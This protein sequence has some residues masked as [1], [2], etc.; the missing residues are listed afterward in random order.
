[1]LDKES[2]REIAFQYAAEVRRVLNPDAV[3]LFGSYANG[4]PHAMSDIDIAVIMNLFQG[5]WLE[6]SALLSSLKRRISIDIEPHLLDETRDA[7]GFVE[8]VLRT[9]EVLYSNPG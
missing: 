6:T 9:G 8:H 4:T 2:A 5:D 3:I 7:S 1:M